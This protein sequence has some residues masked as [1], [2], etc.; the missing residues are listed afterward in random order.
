MG[1]RLAAGLATL[2]TVLGS[3]AFGAL[4]VLDERHGTL[5]DGVVPWTI[6]WYLVAFAGFGAAVVAVE[7]TLRRGRLDLRWWGWLV[8]VPVAFRLALWLTEPTL[9]DDVYRYLWDGHL[10]TSGV[11]P[12]AHPVA[13]PALDPYDVGIRSLVN[14]PT[15]S[16]PY[17]PAAEGLFAV[18]AWL[19]P[20]RP[21]SMQAVMTAFDLATAGLLVRLLGAAG[22]PP[23]RVVLYLWN[24]LVVVETAHG[25]HLDAFMTALTLGAVGATWV[26]TAGRADRRWARI[27]GPVLAAAA[28]LTRGLPALAVPVLWW[29]WTWTGRVVAGL[30]VTVPVAIM[31]R[32]VGLGLDEG[33]V[34]AGT[35]VF[36][37]S[38]AYA[39]LWNFNAPI[40]DLLVRW[41]PGPDPGATARV[42][43]G[44]IMVLLCGA[45]AVGARRR[46]IAAGT[47][48]DHER[49]LDSRRRDVR[50]LAVL[51]GAYAL[52][53][54]TLHPWY[55]VLMMALLPLVVP[56]P[57]A[58]RRHTIGAW[59][60]L[61]PWLYLAGA[62]SLSYL[63]YQ[64]PAAHAERSWVRAVEWL[65]T[66]ILL[67]TAGAWWSTTR[68]PAS[69]PST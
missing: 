7:R 8:A 29:R 42:V 28:V 49:E 47:G 54:T 43:V 16:T 22:L 45:V 68:P 30:A 20:L 65:P 50:D 48:I 52:L 53:T 13:S 2:A 19:G 17:L 56:P 21:I 69:E 4:V 44:V 60:T 31:A 38:R 6:G 36:G 62:I 33:S 11:N 55:L 32:G 39:E 23:A 15:Y 24:P 27:A 14:N 1:D 9:S 46:A 57:A 25:A 18:T 34:A 10:L 12:Y 63:T 26:G 67:A 3:V 37:S 51:V 58:A 35:G 41:S 59:L 61:A 66:V 5:R 64:D 40:F